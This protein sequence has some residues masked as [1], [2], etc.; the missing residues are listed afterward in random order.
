MSDCKKCDNKAGLSILLV[1]PGAIAKD[2]DL[3]PAEAARLRTH[4]ATVHA[5]GLPGLDASRHVLR[6]LRRGGFVYVYYT[7]RLPQLINRWQAYRVQDS[8]VL[9]PESEIAW[10]DTRARF[11]CSRKE[12][13]PHDL[14]T[15]CIQLPVDQPESAGPVWIGFSM[16]WWDEGMRAK[17]QKEPAAAGMVR[18]N[19]LA[20]L[21]GVKHAFK[22]DPF[23]IQ[24][25]VADFA[26][27]SMNHGGTKEGINVTRGGVEPATPFYNGD[28]D[29]SYG[30]GRGLHD[31]MQRQA[32]GHSATRGKEF[33]LALPDPVGLDADLNGI[34]MAKDAAHRKEWLS[35]NDWM[36][37]QACYS[38]LQGLREALLAMAL[39]KAQ[40]KGARASEHSWKYQQLQVN[41]RYP[42]SSYTWMPDADGS[43]ASDGS[44]NG[45]I[46]S[47][48]A[49]AEKD[50]V[51]D[52]R[53]GEEAGRNK[54]A[55][56]LRQLDQ[57]KFEAWPEK[58]DAI[59]QRQ[60]QAMRPYEQD[61][62][63]AL[64]CAAMRDYF[65]NHFDENDP[66]KITAQCSSGTVYAE[67]AD[68]VCYPQPLAHKDDINQ[69]LELTLGKDIG[70][71]DAFALRAF[72]GNHKES[73]D[74][75]KELLVGDWDRGNDGNMRDKT[76][77]LMRGVLNHELAR[78]YNWL[79]PRVVALSMGGLAS[80]V[81]GAMQLAAMAARLPK[82][83]PPAGL[84]K[85]FRTLPP[86]TLAQQAIERAMTAST[87]RDKS[88]LLLPVLLTAEVDAKEFLQF[89]R[90]SAMS[91]AEKRAAT[92]ATQRV[93]GSANGASGAKTF[94]IM[95]LTDAQTALHVHEDKL[96]VGNLGGAGP[97]GAG[98]GTPQGNRRVSSLEAQASALGS[99]R[100]DAH[101]LKEVVHRTEAI[102]E[103]RVNS[104]EVRM[105]SGALIVQSLGLYQG[106]RQIN[107]QRDRLFRDDEKFQEAVLGT[108]DSAGGAIGALAE[109][110]GG[111]Y[112]GVLLRKPGGLELAE[113]SLPLAA[114]RVTSAVMGMAGGSINAYLMYTKAKG[115]G[116][117]GDRGAHYSY[118]ASMVG[119][120][121][122]T[123]TSTYLLAD[124]TSLAASRAVASLVLRLSGAELAA[125]AASS[126][127]SGVGVF[128]L[129]V[130]VVGIVVAS[131]LERDA[132]ERW[133]GGCY[134][135]G[136]APD[137][138]GVSP[139]KKKR[140]TSAI[141]EAAAFEL[142]FDA[143]AA[144]AE[145]GK[146]E[147]QH[148][149]PRVPGEQEGDRTPDIDPNID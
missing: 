17:V 78:K 61:W 88:A 135:G 63:R 97:A 80:M 137:E 106:F 148:P 22:A 76:V 65:K 54:W 84:A 83:P 109:V 90:A 35:N 113:K 1:R 120:T 139:A 82:A 77:D 89:V 40:R 4:D 30:Q 146:L 28:H 144:Q 72:F 14:R 12:S 110:A 11:A 131:I 18:I 147:R 45:R 111:A 103:Y 98:I 104:V 19:P 126:F 79:H 67:E 50:R 107:E 16:N 41:P 95:V 8:G 31:V 39:Q 122:S 73:I 130:G 42:R 62:L 108:I 140:F 3:A 114:V 87:G 21:G 102:Q 44:R 60:A 71:T 129:L 74:K 123:A 56:I 33:V 81:A 69:W 143:V 5:L 112:K 75:A 24:Q 57:K 20:D 136:D 34:R 64:D 141:E 86:L 55:R 25:Y 51:F 117:K 23:S 138:P 92:Q 94:K 26:L 47:I 134:F 38:T 32:A 49:Q 132:F 52:A 105:A 15:L 118:G 10:D 149:A 101:E 7:K 68:R 96:R 43:R 59:L 2:A 70:K 125:G 46:V 127:V 58:R 142:I 37:S 93:A 85:W 13:H 29:K 145:L 53:Q 91:S 6:M 116:E 100:L 119:F 115:A 27:R 9:I 128:L 48:G 99:S 124:A 133:A 66:G 121:F 36:R